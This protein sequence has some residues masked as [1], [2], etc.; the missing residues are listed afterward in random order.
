VSVR[1]RDNDLGPVATSVT[2]H[3]VERRK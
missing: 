3:H 2:I 1:Y